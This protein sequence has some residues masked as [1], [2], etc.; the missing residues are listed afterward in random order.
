MRRQEM[1]VAV[2]ETLV[3]ES[4]RQIQ[5]AWAYFARALPAGEVVAHDG[6]LVTDGRS[7]PAFMNAAFLTTPVRDVA[8]VRTRLEEASAHFRAHDMPCSREG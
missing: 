8:D 7:P 4:H 1:R 2:P 3:T 6:L 5:L